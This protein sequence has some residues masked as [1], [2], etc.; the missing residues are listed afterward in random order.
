MRDRFAYP[1]EKMSYQLD[2]HNAAVDDATVKMI[3]FSDALPDTA[4]MR[5][6][7]ASIGV[8]GAQA[9]QAD[10]ATATSARPSESATYGGSADVKYLQ[11]AYTPSGEGYLGGGGYEGGGGGGGGGAGPGGRGTGF[12]GGSSDTGGG[13]GGGGGG[14]GGSFLDALA[15]VESG[16]Q[17][18]PS[19][20]DPDVAG[21]GTKS[22]GYFQINTPTWRDFA[23]KAGVDLKQYPNAMSAPRDVQARV[24][25]VIPFKRFGPRTQRLMR[26]RF[27][28]IDSNMTVGELAA[29]KGTG[30][31]PAAPATA[32]GGS[33]EQAQGKVAGIRKGA[34]DADLV[35]SLEYAAEATGLKVRVTS[36][37]QRMEGA[38][39]H[40]GSHRHD[41]GRAADFDLI[42]PETGKVLAL[43]DPRRVQFLEEAAAAGAGGIGTQYM[44]APAKIH[45]GTTQEGAYAGPR[46]EREAVA[47]GL[48][49]KMS[50]AE[51]REAREMQKRAAEA[52]AKAKEP[53]PVAETPNERDVTTQ[54]N[55]KVNDTHVQFARTSIKRAADREVREAR[56]NS[57]SDIGAA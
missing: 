47:R 13:G 7:K 21:P 11:A 1:A 44:D 3:A 9:T 57:Y 15:D 10:F 51:V 36:G 29:T 32:G 55:L 25:S 34:L 41:Q 22:Q 2:R 14:S 35:E 40:T 45:A 5:L 27:G 43:D 28:D 16:N 39:G 54:V 18:I 23:G 19:G 37:G 26:Q 6:W 24:A 8:P 38:P 33:V 50:R 53:A 42:D 52:N 30:Y 31:T 49:R 4:Q 48:K 17:N 56:W 12:G 20:V 46:H